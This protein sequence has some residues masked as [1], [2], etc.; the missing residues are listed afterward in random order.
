MHR[1]G[2]LAIAQAG[3]A[4]NAAAASRDTTLA[5]VAYSTPKEAFAK[6]IP[7]FQTTPAGRG[8]TFTQS[9]GPSGDQA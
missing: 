2:P 9:Y 7:A 3:A 5:L 4:T 6:I 8:I 1:I